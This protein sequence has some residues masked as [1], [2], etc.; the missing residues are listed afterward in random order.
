R[1]F[2]DQRGTDGPLTTE[3]ESFECAPQEEIKC[4]PRCRGQSSENT[5]AKDDD[6]E[7]INSSVAVGEVAEDNTACC[8][9]N[10]ANRC[11]PA[12]GSFA[13]PQYW[14][15]GGKGKAI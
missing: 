15:S 14:H 8:G 6:R 4:V 12:G 13:H 9:R 2:S 10:D 11:D 1:V 7:H 3:E 5:V